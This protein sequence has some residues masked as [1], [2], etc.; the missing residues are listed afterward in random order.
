M[1]LMPSSRTSSPRQRTI[2]AAVD[3]AD[4]A[5]TPGRVF[6][7]QGT[8]LEEVVDEQSDLFGGYDADDWSRDIEGN[9]T[10]LQGLTDTPLIFTSDT[11]AVVDGM[12]FVGRED[13]ISA[14][15]GLPDGAEV[16]VY[17]STVHGRATSDASYGIAA[18][19]DNTLR[20]YDVRIQAPL[21]VAAVEQTCHQAV[22]VA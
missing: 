9:E 11:V 12:T 1:I 21:L 14:G 6:I 20:L 15:M 2:Q 13:S 4:K 3:E 19:S 16:S 17:R 10:I 18:S 8:Y 5:S 22:R 7:A